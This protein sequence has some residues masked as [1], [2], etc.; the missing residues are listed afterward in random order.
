M[1]ITEMA[2]FT[3]SKTGPEAPPL[4]AE[5]APGVTLD[6][7]KEATGFEFTVADPLPVMLQ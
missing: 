1:V 4:L 2:V 7:V 6:Q 5:I 3:F